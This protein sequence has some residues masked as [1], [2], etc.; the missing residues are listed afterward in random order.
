MLARETGRAISVRERGRS[1]RTYDDTEAR[2][3]G[4]EWE[5]VVEGGSRDGRGPKERREM[6]EVERRATC[7][8]AV[9]DGVSSGAAEEE[10]V[11]PTVRLRLRIVTLGGM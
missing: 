3:L 6:P 8:V 4:R 7:F 10:D 2:E 5:S 11:L 9:D 1:G